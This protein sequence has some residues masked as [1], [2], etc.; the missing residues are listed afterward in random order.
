MAD[1]LYRVTLRGF[2]TDW[3]KVSYVVAQHAG[4]AYGKVREKIAAED[5]G[6][7]NDRELDKVELL[8]DVAEYPPCNCRLFL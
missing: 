1:K 4:E 7:V 6:F 8:A 2:T 5:A 3:R